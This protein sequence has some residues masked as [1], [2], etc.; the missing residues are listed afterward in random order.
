MGGLARGMDLGD[1][2]VIDR[3]N[4]DAGCEHLLHLDQAGDT[5]LVAAHPAA[6]EDEEKQGCGLRGLR[7]PEI[8]HLPFV[9]AVDD[10]REGR[11][12]RN[13]LHF[14]RRRRFGG[15]GLAGFFRG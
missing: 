14:F 1:V 12:G 6:A 2:T 9:R 8:Q 3:N 4:R 5:D 7:L 11:F 13:G 15:R 10:V